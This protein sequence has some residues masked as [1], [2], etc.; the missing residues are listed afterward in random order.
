MG[1]R[2]DCDW[3]AKGTCNGPAM[4]LQWACNGDLQWACNGTCN[5]PQ[6]PPA[7]GL[8]WDC[9]GPAMGLQWACNGPAMGLQWPCNGPAMGLQWACNGRKSKKTISFISK[10]GGSHQNQSNSVARQRPL[11]PHCGLIA[12]MVVF[13]CASLQELFV[14]VQELRDSRRPRG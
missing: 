8:Q 2:W 12:G 9:D 6:T 1:L 3:P 10:N 5:G 14:D 11:R 4:G 7:M 13:F